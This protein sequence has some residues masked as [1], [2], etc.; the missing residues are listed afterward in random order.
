[1]K[2]TTERI[3]Q[4]GEYLA[5]ILSLV[6]LICVVRYQ[7]NYKSVAEEEEEE[8]VPEYVFCT[9]SK[10]SQSQLEIY[11][12]AIESMCMKYGIHLQ[13]YVDKSFSQQVYNYVKEQVNSDEAN[14]TVVFMLY[15]RENEIGIVVGGQRDLDTQF[16]SACAKAFESEDSIDKRLEMLVKEISIQLE[17]E[18]FWKKNVAYDLVRRGG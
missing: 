12:L 18:T 1:M 7:I 5:V 2:K 15:S 8:N 17:E 13:I 4:L 14:D 10:V 6:L 11:D 3:F 9:D 16:L